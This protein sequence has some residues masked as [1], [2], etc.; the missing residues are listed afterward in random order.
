MAFANK[1]EKENKMAFANKLNRAD[2]SK[3]N[4]FKNEMLIDREKKI[5]RD[6][7]CLGNCIVK[8]SYMDNKIFLEIMPT[9][10]ANF[11]G[12]VEGIIIDVG[13]NDCHVSSLM[14]MAKNSNEINKENQL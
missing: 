5:F 13:E 2:K 11:S 12:D 7:K 3:W 1:S 10:T 14:K 6:P 4:C 9:E 8:A